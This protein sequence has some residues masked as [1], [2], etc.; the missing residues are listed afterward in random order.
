LSPSSSRHRLEQLGALGE[1]AS[2]SAARS[3]LVGSAG[4]GIIAASGA[5]AG[6]GASGRGAAAAFRSGSSLPS[7]NSSSA[8]SMVAESSPRQNWKSMKSLEIAGSG[9]AVVS[10]TGGDGSS[11]LKETRGLSQPYGTAAAGRLLATAEVMAGVCSAHQS[12][13]VL[14]WVAVGGE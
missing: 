10:S 13:V 9:V 6:A 12:P 11:R 1:N 7:A 8:G 2:A 3:G 5:G 14:C 4:A